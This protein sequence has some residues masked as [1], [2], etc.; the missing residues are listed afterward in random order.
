MMFFPT[1]DGLPLI[2]YHRE[3]RRIDG[4][5]RFDLND[6]ARPFEQ[7]DALYRTGIAV[8]DYPVD[9]HHAA[10]PEDEELP[11]LHFYPVP[12]YTLPLGTLIPESVSDFIV[13][14][15]SISVT[16]LVNGTTRLQPV[17]LLIGQA[18][19]ALAALAAN[20]G[21]S[22]EEVPVRM[23]QQALLDSKGYLLPY[24]DVSP[25]SNSFRAVQKIGVTGIL[26]GEG[27]NIGWE[28]QTLFYPDSLVSRSALHTGLRDIAPEFS[29]AGKNETLTMNEALGVIHHLTKI[30]P[31]GTNYPSR[32]SMD[33]K[34]NEVWKNHKKEPLDLEAN[35]T[36][37]E[38][39][40]LLNE[41]ADP[42]SNWPVDHRGAFSF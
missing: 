19:G 34:A 22:P 8:G 33:E 9:H 16:N 18:A 20:N 3:S 5:V 37:E 36:R 1:T 32:K 4:I 10:Y 15:K 25:T 21:V 11:D 6:L 39:C 30:R 14:E 26:R 35:I 38:F 29:I 31:T 42:F 17:C 12:S 7:H 13:A 40:V 24:L 41:L 28:N 27:K 23:V 2:P